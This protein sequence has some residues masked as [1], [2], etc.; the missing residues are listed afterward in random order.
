MVLK[1][2][3]SVLVSAVRSAAEAVVGRGGAG[4][5]GEGRGLAV[6]MSYLILNTKPTAEV[7]SGQST[8]HFVM[9]HK[10]KSH[11]VMTAVTC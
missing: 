7:V 11:T 1:I 8:V 5:G 3:D 10:Y 6:V 9:C 4:R 2:C